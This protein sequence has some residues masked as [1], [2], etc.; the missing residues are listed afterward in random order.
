MAVLLK[1]KKLI[2]TIKVYNLYRHFFLELCLQGKGMQCRY[3]LPLLILDATS[4]LKVL[5]EIGGF[6]RLYVGFT[7]L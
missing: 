7:F 6:K 5:V 3:H 4:K 1:I 2:I